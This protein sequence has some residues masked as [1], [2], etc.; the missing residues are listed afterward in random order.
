MK[1]Q[2]SILSVFVGDCQ[3]G[4]IS[5]EIDYLLRLLNWT[6]SS[7]ILVGRLESPAYLSLIPPSFE[8]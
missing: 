3:K 7:S 6:K 5:L 1:G 2:E 8:R 4:G